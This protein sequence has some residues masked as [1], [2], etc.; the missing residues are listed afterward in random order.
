MGCRLI[1]DIR[2]LGGFWVLSGPRPL[3]YAARPEIACL[4]PTHCRPQTA[5]HW[6][7]NILRC[8]NGLV[9]ALPSIVSR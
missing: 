5:R 1:P 3:R 6:A 9:Q 8:G 2:G 4:L 7:I